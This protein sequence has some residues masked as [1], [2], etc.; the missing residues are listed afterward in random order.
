MVCP[1]GKREIDLEQSSDDTF[2]WKLKKK[3]NLTQ[4]RPSIF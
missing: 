2:H 3:E 4:A 1:K